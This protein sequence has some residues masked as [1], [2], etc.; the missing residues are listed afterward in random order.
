MKRHGL[1]KRERLQRPADFE[2]TYRARNSTADERLIVYARPNALK[3]SRLGLSVAGR[4]G[5]AVRRNRFR[6]IC[7]EAYRLHK[8]EI[9][10]G[11]DIIVIPRRG[12]ELTLDEVARSLVSLAGRVCQKRGQGK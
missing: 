8:H 9:P 1:A 11:Y 10:P 3:L 2:A 5:N 7:R 6:R 4:W 12:I